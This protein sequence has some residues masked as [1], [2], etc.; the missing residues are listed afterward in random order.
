MTDGDLSG[1]YYAKARV[2]DDMTKVSLH[3][4]GLPVLST[5]LKSV[6][7]QEG[8]GYLLRTGTL[9]DVPTN[10][11]AF[12]SGLGDLPKALAT[13]TGT[14]FVREQDA[15]MKA[16]IEQA[17]SGNSEPLRN[18]PLWV[19]GLDFNRAREELNDRSRCSPPAPL[20]ARSKPR[21]RR[22]AA[23]RTRS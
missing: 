15:L 9:V 2:V 14:T 1:G 20:R 18:F 4:S 21:W 11:V 6:G 17:K 8:G 10:I 12:A 7:R 19:S 22:S 13:E 16:A 23:A 3:K 5:Q